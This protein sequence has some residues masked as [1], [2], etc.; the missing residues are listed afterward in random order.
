MLLWGKHLYAHICIN[1]SNIHFAV[2][3]MTSVSKE[4]HQAD[5]KVKI[6]H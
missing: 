2:L 3:E 5:L 1:V 6:Y 4:M